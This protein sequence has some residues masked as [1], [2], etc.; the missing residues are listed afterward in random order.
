MNPETK[1]TQLKTKLNEI[2]DLY[3]T[4]GLLQWDQET[5]MPPGGSQGRGYQL[6]TLSR[7]SHIKFT[8]AEI[9]ELLND[10]EPYTASL[11]P[12]SDDA[13]LVKVTRRL[14]N[15]KV[16]VPSE[17]VA[18]FARA[19]SEAHPVWEKAKREADFSPFRPKLERIVDL[20]RQYAQCF[21]PYDHI[22]DP[23]LDD[24]EPGLKTADVQAIFSA[25]RTQQ[26][27]L[28]QAIAARPQVDDSFLHQPYDI[29]K[30]RQFGEEVITRFGFDWERGRQDESTHPFTQDIGIGDVRITTRFLPEYVASA[31]FSSTHESGHALYIMGIDPK[32]ER[33][34]LAGGASLA[35]HE[36]Q[37]RLYENLVARSRDFWVHFYPRLQSL[38]P[39]QLGEIPLD[40][41][42]KAI[43]RVKPS[44]I[45]VEADEATYNLHVMLRLELEIALM[46][47]SL[48]VQDLPEAWNERMWTYLGVKPNN[49]AEGV[50][51][52]IHWAHGHIGYF[53]TY[54]LGNLISAQLWERMLQDLPDLPEQIRRGEFAA[55]TGWMREKVHRHGAKFEPQE[56]VQR[57]TG[58][59]I[60][61]APYLRY[62]R[63]KYT[64][65]YEL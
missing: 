63:K 5:Y 53:S 43:N 7:I 1:L 36:S 60:D 57:V 52:D 48:A 47:G 44:L 2:A 31:L 11:D 24:F 33:T 35:V 41:F 10:L 14:Y 27:E 22:Y 20:R 15:K 12:D 55:L 9:G 26:V 17:L 34:P 3:D 65:I 46:E 28:I 19:A 23:L 38:F 29:Q 4:I 32:L 18:A 13:R 25:L 51:Q 8:S 49:D 62:L 42:Y 54:A 37:S 64:E 21:V 56:L 59:K 45:R 61:S 40:K 39:A 50:L 6:E 30:Q 58:Q 16:K